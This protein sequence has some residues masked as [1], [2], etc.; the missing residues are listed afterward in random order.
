MLRCPFCPKSSINSIPSQSLGH[1]SFLVK[2]WQFDSKFYMEM[3]NNINSSSNFEKGQKMGELYCL[4][5]FPDSA[6]SKE[7]AC[8]CKDAGDEGSISESG[9]S[10]E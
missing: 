6:S 1:F 9:R 2:K 8:Q 5:V 7:S 4:V 10:L 3:Q